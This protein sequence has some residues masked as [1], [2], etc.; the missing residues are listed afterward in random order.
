[1]HEDSTSRVEPILDELVG[2]GKELQE[3]FIVNIIDFYDLLLEAGEELGVGLEPQDGQ[4]M[5]DAGCLQSIP[6]PQ[7][8]KSTRNQ[9]LRGENVAWLHAQERQRTR[10]CTTRRRPALCRA[11]TLSGFRR[12][13]GL[14]GRLCGLW[15]CGCSCQDAVRDA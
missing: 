8:E 1:M 9:S 13:C 14:L 11:M 5:R 2:V 4:D 3:V 6:P 12:R 10:Q 7:R 15:W